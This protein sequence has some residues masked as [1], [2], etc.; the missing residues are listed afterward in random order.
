ML[1][2]FGIITVFTLAVTMTGCG[3]VHETW[4]D[5]ER[6]VHKWIDNAFGIH[7]DEHTHTVKDEPIDMGVWAE[8]KP[9]LTTPSMVEPKKD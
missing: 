7:A 3:Q 2:T 5:I 1:K 9:I 6:P 8:D 4:H